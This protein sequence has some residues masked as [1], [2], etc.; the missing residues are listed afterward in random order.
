[1][2]NTNMYKHIF[3]LVQSTHI[4]IYVLFYI[5]HYNICVLNILFLATTGLNIT[6][7]SSMKNRRAMIRRVQEKLM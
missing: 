6:N 7:S 5:L 1:M 2:N 4:F 3:F